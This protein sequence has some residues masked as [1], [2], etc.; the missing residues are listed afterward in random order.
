[1]TIDHGN[2]VRTRYAHCEEISVKHGQR[3]KRGEIIATVGNTGVATN[4]HV[5]YEVIVNG[6]HIDP[7]TFMFGSVIVD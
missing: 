4:Y 3:V 2:G 7:R 1:V 6:R 5:H